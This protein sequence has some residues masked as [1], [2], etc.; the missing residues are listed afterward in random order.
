[1]MITNTLQQTEL[2]LMDM[3]FQ[4]KCPYIYREVHK[5]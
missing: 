5:S 4:E 3:D 1:M 2:L